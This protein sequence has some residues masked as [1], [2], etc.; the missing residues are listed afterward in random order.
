M[1]QL[2]AGALASILPG[3]TVSWLYQLKQVVNYLC[4]SFLDCKMG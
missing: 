2:K 3:S 1:A 4:L